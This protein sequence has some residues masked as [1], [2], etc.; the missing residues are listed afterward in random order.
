MPTTR[1]IQSDHLAEERLQVVGF[2]LES[3]VGCD[4]NS[5][6]PSTGIRRGGFRE[7]FRRVRSLME[8]R[9]SMQSS[10]VQKGASILSFK[11][12]FDCRFKYVNVYMF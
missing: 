10:R 6:S 2:R 11:S 3:V 9:S 12:I 1:T 7:G 8:S 4:W 5:W